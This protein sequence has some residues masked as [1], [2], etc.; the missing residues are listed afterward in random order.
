MSGLGA[1]SYGDYY[2]NM[3]V[4]DDRVAAGIFAFKQE[5]IYCGYG[6]GIKLDL[7]IFGNMVKARLIDFQ[8]YAGLDPDGRMWS[9]DARALFR[10]RSNDIQRSRGIPYSYL[11]KIKTLESNND[12]VAQGY[13]DDRDEG[14]MQFHL[15]YWPDWTKEMAWNPALAMPAAADKMV[16]A[17]ASTGSWKGAVAAHNIGVPYAALWVSEDYPAEGG[18]IMGVDAQGNPIYAFTRATNYLRLVESVRL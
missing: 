16:N 5:L 8:K 17:K 15:P 9:N 13:V 18:P 11:A 7:P 6:D 1:W 12:P 3:P 10:K 2:Y 4:P 14:I